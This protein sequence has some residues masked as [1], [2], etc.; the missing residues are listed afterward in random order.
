MKGYEQ[1]D[2]PTENDEQNDYSE[3]KEMV[4]GGFK[5]DSRPNPC[6]VFR[7]RESGAY[8]GRDQRALRAFS[9]GKQTPRHWEG[10]LNTT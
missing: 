5:Q 6:I 2:A 3:K 9:N 7:T 1:N 8:G 4:M 10:R